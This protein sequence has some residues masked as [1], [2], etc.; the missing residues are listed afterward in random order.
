MEVYGSLL[1]TKYELTLEQL[2]NFF[3]LEESSESITEL[4]R[5]FCLQ[6]SS[7]DI[8]K[9]GMEFLYLHGYFDDLMKLIKKNKESTYFS[10]NQ[11]ADI[12]QLMMNLKKNGELAYTILPKL[13]QSK[14]SDPELI[15][16]IEI[17]KAYCYYY[18]N[19]VD[20]LGYILTTYQQ[21]FSVIED[22]LLVSY[23]K[24]RIQQ[25]SLIYF[26]KQNELITA[27]R[28]AYQT[29]KE[30]LNP[31]IHVDV[32]I[33]LGLSYTFESLESGMYHLSEALRI[34]KKYH[35]DLAV[36]II[37]QHNIPFLSAHFNQV[38]NISTQDKSEQAHIEIA[39]G[40]N[41]KAIEILNELPLNTPF[42]IYYLGKAKRDKQLLLKSYLYFMDKQ[43]DHFFSKLPL[44]ELKQLN[45]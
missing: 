36:N 34:S 26:M 6:S 12:Y 29:L 9:K 2:H 42:Q 38:E 17:A 18:M 35:Y 27:R 30:T 31:F 19:R 5:R 7:L 8:Q 40:N 41:D 11:W 20:K 28:F 45:H 32:H 43:S 25:L 22:R 16:L 13:N 15:C 23:F 33:K 21:L 37:E 10:N 4:T 14:T 44:C 39:K 24:I 1:S 3:L